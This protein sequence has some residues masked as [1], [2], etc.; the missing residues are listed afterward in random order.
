MKGLEGQL[1]NLHEKHQ[2]LLQSYNKQVD[3][4]SR[5]NGRI[6]QLSE[7]L[8]SIKH[9]QDSSFNDMITN[10][11]FDSFDAFSSTELVYNPSDS[12]Y[13]KEPM[14][15]NTDFCLDFEDSL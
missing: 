13:D 3:E 5:L 10:D 1:E 6:T 11:R 12:Y 8:S 2:D 15:L 7:E 14:D 9:G 4:V